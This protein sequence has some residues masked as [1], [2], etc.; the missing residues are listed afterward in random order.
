VHILH[1]IVNNALERIARIGL[2]NYARTK[3][4]DETIKIV[5]QSGRYWEI[6]YLYLEQ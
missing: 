2:M 1:T 4:E 6:F 5:L 3:A